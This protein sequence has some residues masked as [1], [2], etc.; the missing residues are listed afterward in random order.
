MA[1]ITPRIGCGMLHILH[2]YHS[3]ARMHYVLIVHFTDMFLVRIFHTA[4]KEVR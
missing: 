1:A 3:A 2:Q 4:L